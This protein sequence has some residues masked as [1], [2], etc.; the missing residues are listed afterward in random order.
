MPIS[1]LGHLMSTHLMK[2]FPQRQQGKVAPNNLFD[3]MPSEAQN[4]S[5]CKLPIPSIS[6]KNYSKCL[7]RKI[8]L[9]S[10]YTLDIKDR[11]NIGTGHKDSGITKSV[12]NISV[13]HNNYRN[14][15]S[16]DKNIH[17]PNYKNYFDYP[18]ITGNRRTLYS[19]SNRRISRLIN[20]SK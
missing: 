8:N 16:S 7:K 6:Y 18:N 2:C 11:R 13:K 17:Q 14:E 1:G 12:N 5:R 15:L 20:K 3:K 10:E 9:Y 19:Y 4:L